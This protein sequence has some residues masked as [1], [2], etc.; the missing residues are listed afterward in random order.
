MRMSA[1]PMRGDPLEV[2]GFPVRAAFST[3]SSGPDI[4]ETTYLSRITV[5]L[6]LQTQ[7]RYADG[8]SE[9]YRG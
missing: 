9:G 3:A 7:P 6:Y 2:D 1:G 4:V 8:P 5:A